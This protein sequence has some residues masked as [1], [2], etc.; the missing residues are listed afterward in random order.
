MTAT[1]NREYTTAAQ[2]LNV[3]EKLNDFKTYFTDNDL[4]R[5]YTETADINVNGTILKCK[6]EAFAANDITDDTAYHVQLIVDDFIEIHRISFFVD[7]RE[8]DYAMTIDEM[9]ITHQRYNLAQ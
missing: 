8:G 1:I 5:M 3:K 9:L 2:L 7:E 4:L 6:V